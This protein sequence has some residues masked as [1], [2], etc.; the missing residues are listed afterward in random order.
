MLLD[1]AG[2]MSA[3][4]PRLA[5]SRSRPVLV[6]RYSQVMHIVLQ[7]RSR[8][9]HDAIR[10]TRCRR[11]SGRYGIGAPKVRAMQISM[12]GK[13]KRSLY[14]GCVGYFSAGEEMDSCMCCARADQ[15]GTMYVQA[16]AG[17][18]ADSRSGLRAAGMHQ[19]GQ[20]AVP[21][22]RG[23]KR[24]AAVARGGSRFRC[25]VD[26]AGTTCRLAGQTF[27]L[28]EKMPHSCCRNFVNAVYGFAASVRAALFG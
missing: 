11:L 26:R 6:E 5:P 22:R 17:I 24:F 2:T 27:A 7:R 13:E 18:V 20:G 19:Q 14:A 25:R 9:R 16:G 1:L 4:S 8:L 21:R 3:A 12:I 28:F 15:D 10:S 23:S